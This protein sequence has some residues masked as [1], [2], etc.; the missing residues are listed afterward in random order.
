MSGS[1]WSSSFPRASLW[2]VLS[3]TFVEI[4]CDEQLIYSNVNANAGARKE[5]EAKES[6]KDSA[7]P[8]IRLFHYSE[9]CSKSCTDV[10]TMSNRRSNA[11]G[12]RAWE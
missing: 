9:H 10:D 3:S 5:K 2:F 1:F 6:E 7:S 8:Y 11:I 12:L 4:G